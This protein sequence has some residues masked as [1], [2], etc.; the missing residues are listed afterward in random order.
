MLYTSSGAVYGK[1]PPARTCLN[2][3]A[4]ISPP[5]LGPGGAYAEAKRFGELYCALAGEAA[6][7]EVKLARGFTFTGPYLPLDGPLA[8]GNFVD[9]VL[10]G[11][12]ILVKSAGTAVRSYLYGADLAGWLWTILTRGVHARP[13]NV[14]SDQPVSILDVARLVAQ[15][16]GTS[17]QV[18]VTEA[19]GPN[20]PIDYYVPDITRARQELGLDVWT[21]LPDAIG[22]TLAW[23][24]ENRGLR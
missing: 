13:Y 3:D 5:D 1:R 2:E 18:Q 12:D 20:D 15:L 17:T 14:G 22:R 7:I 21:R 11:R 9:D 8:V 4:S 16:G 23:H 10:R 24:R 19:A 6:G